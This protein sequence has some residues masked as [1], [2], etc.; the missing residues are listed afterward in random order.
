MD[1]AR[2]AR[3]SGS[4]A[5]SRDPERFRQFLYFNLPLPIQK[6]QRTPQTRQRRMIVVLLESSVTPR[7]QSFG[8]VYGLIVSQRLSADEPCALRDIDNHQQWLETAS[9]VMQPEA[10][11]ARARQMSVDWFAEGLIQAR[12]VCG[13]SLYFS[14]RKSSTGQEP[15]EKKNA[16]SCA[17]LDS[18][19]RLPH[20]VRG[21]LH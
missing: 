1:R 14:M 8:D 7:V 16:S 12:C 20:T 6:R 5:Y 3:D 19:G 13:S 15:P 2:H 11:S 21:L 10:S 17:R 18:R 4:G 9:A